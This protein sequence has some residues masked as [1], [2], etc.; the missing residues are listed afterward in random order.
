MHY[1]PHTI[2]DEAQEHSSI[3]RERVDRLEQKMLA[4]P[5]V[6]CPVRHHFAPG[7]YAREIN[8]P[9]G[10]VLIGVVHKTDNLVIVS[11]GRLQIVTDTGTTLLEAGDILLCKA[12][13]KNAAIALEDTRWTNFLH[14]PDDVRDTAQLVELFAHAKESDLLGGHTN[15]Q[16]AAN[17]AALKESVPCHL[18]Q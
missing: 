10:T 3:A 13:T 15:R 11:K 7:I 17:Q 14:N 4:L 6:D 12:G 16:L 5:Q 18:A 1:L 2:P 9:K 8:I